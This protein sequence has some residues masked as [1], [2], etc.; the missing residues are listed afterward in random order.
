MSRWEDSLGVSGF[1]LCGA[2]CG[3]W[4]NQDGANGCILRG[5][6]G[7]QWASVPVLNG[8][9]RPPGKLTKEESL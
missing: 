7:R 5:G 8:I 1:G 6:I 2:F 9:E 4:L 3:Y